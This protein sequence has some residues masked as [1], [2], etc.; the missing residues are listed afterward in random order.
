MSLTRTDRQPDSGLA[1]GAGSLAEGSACGWGLAGRTGL[2]VAAGADAVVMA[3]AVGTTGGCAGS[4]FGASTTLAAGAIAAG[5]LA[6]DAVGD[7]GAAFFDSR[8]PKLK[9][10]TPNNNTPTA[11]NAT[12]RREAKGMR[13]DV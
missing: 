8:R 2:V 5:A 6:I 3:L 4:S 9:S 11:A 10:T 12:Q 13:D 1:T 7:A